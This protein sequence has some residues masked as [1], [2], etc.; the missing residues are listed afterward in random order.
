VNDKQR[1]V[2]LAVVL[3]IGLMLIYPPFVFRGA[4]GFTKNMGYGWIFDPP[5]ANL[6]GSVDVAMLLTQWFGV[7][8]IGAIAFFLCKGE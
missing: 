4:N 3:A 5:V 8:V 2:L 1:V 7:A 6:A